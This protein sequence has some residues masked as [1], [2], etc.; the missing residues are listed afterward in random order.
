MAKISKK[1]KINKIIMEDKKSIEKGEIP[2]GTKPITRKQ[3]RAAVKIDKAT[4]YLPVDEVEK[5][6][7]VA[8]AH[9]LWLY[10]I[11]LKKHFNI[12]GPKLVAFKEHIKDIYR[13]AIDD[14]SIEG[15]GPIIEYT[16]RGSKKEDEGN[17][18]YPEFEQEEFDPAGNLYKHFVETS[19]NLEICMQRYKKMARCFCEF[20][21]CEVAA[22]LVL[23][24]YL[25]FAR[26]RLKRF[27]ETSRE[28]FQNI[29]W[30][31]YENNIL[32]LE[33]LCKTTFK[34][35]DCIRG[36]QGILWS[37]GDAPIF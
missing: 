2:K 31:E 26:K 23:K 21:K 30:A 15:T 33:K 32:Y 24:D 25:G 4:D 18:D 22:L 20:D 17:M 12:T 13:Y 8:R 37:I 3:V 27:I 35:F 7:S 29:T 36:G 9:A 11:V 34:E 10:M 19:P 16:I 6:K 14:K 1:I 28:T 5:I